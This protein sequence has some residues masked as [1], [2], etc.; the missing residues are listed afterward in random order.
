MPLG[1]TP[2]SATAINC[3]A[4]WIDGLGSG[5]PDTGSGGGGGPPPPM[6]W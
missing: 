5:G 3:V 1:G 2:L 4:D 6:G